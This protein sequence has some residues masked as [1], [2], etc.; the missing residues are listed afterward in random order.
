MLRKLMYAF[1]V[2][3]AAGAAFVGTSFAVNTT[4][5]PDLPS[6]LPA[7]KLP[8]S[9]VPETNRIAIS[10]LLAGQAEQYGVNDKS[11]VHARVLAITS[12]G[13]LYAIP[14]ANGICLA[15]GS[16][17][18]CSDDISNQDRAV[19]VALFT[20]TADH[21][22]VGGGL[23]SSSGK[24]VAVAFDGGQRVSLRS[25]NGVFVASSGDRLSADHFAGL[26]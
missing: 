5:N 21:S 8:V 14:G 24:S 16:A 10:N 4:D 20:P 9:T 22:L 6:W 11:F 17:V 26:G 23:V 19:V 15:L 1:S 7:S 3:A 25:D 13:P 18:A 2:A 12:E